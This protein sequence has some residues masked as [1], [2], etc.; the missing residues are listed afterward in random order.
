MFGRLARG[1]GRVPG[2]RDLWDP[3]QLVRHQVGDLLGRVRHDVAEGRVLGLRRRVDA[4]AGRVAQTS[5]GSRENRHARR[6]RVGQG[7][8]VVRELGVTTRGWVGEVAVGAGRVVRR[9]VRVVALRVVPVAVTRDGV[10]AAFRHVVTPLGYV[11]LALVA[12]GEVGAAPVVRHV[13]R[14]GRGVE[15]VRRRTRG[16]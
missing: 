3:A 12:P 1:N 11:V 2:G 10:E 16:R 8:G 7:V 14:G 9:G 15:Q 6:V 5:A 13:G 4:G